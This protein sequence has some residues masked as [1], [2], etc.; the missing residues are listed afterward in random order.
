MYTYIHT[1][2]Y[3]THLD[4]KTRLNF[5]LVYIHVQVYKCKTIYLYMHVY[6][7]TYICIQNTFGQEDDVELCISIHTRTGI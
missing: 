2:A 3:R 6:I 5:V 4:K 1:Y 7:H